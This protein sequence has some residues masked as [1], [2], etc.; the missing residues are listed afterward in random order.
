MSP[1]RVSVVIP[2]YQRP[3]LLAEALES[4]RTQRFT[5]WECVVADDGTESITRPVVEAFIARDPRFRYVVQPNQGSPGATRNLGIGV[6]RGE[7]I[8]FDDD[9]DVWLPDKLTAQVA[10]LDA[11]PDVL[12][13]FSHVQRFGAEDFVWP[14]G[15]VPARPSLELLLRGN[16]VPTSATVVRRHALDQVGLFDTQ[17]RFGEDFEL[18]LRIARV[19]PVRAL[20]NVHVRYR[21][22]AGGISRDAERELDCLEAIFARAGSDWGLPRGWLRPMIRSL[23]RR[24]ANQA[25]SPLERAKHRLQS[26]LP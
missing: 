3:E 19:G 2:T 18:W 8:A 15:I 1:P 24:R 10:V 22:H 26:W 23:H 7:L 21:V 14:T 16:L 25:S 20:P 5:D 6:T 13:L 12:L 4:V 9:D 11:E 17:L